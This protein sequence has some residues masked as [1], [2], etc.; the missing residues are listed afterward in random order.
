MAWTPLHEPQLEDVSPY[1]QYLPVVIHSAHGTR[2]ELGPSKKQYVKCEQC[3]REVQLFCSG[4]TVAG[5]HG[6]VV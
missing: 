3:R 6:M 1:A 4:L 2:Q 5:L